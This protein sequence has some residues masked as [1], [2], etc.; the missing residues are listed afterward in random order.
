LFFLLA[1]INTSYYMSPS[2]S[3]DNSQYNQSMKI[4]QIKRVRFNLES[5]LTIYFSKHTRIK[6]DLSRMP[7]IEDNF[8]RWGDTNQTTETGVLSVVPRLPRKYTTDI[9]LSPVK[10]S[11]SLSPPRLPVRR[12]S[13]ELE[14]GQF[15]PQRPSRQS[16]KNT[17]LGQPVSSSTTLKDAVLHSYHHKN[18]KDSSLRSP[19]MPRRQGSFSKKV[20]VM[21]LPSPRIWSD[22]NNDDVSPGHVAELKGLKEIWRKALEHCSSLLEYSDGDGSLRVNTVYSRA[23]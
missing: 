7:T 13:G 16:S 14:Q 22:S 3:L 20:S 8:C 18:K 11:E 23:A 12:M 19:S 6:L 10:K 2:V 15:T 5:N 1:V 4:G 21:A 9:L 17:M